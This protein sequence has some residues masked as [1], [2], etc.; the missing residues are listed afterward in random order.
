M[1]YAES[2]YIQNFNNSEEKNFIEHFSREMKAIGT[3]N[4]RKRIM[5]QM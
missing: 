2:F 5:F 1:K 4:W 3:L